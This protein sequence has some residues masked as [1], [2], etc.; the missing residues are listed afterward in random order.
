MEFRIEQYDCLP[1]TN[2]LAMRRGAE[3]EAEG[4]VLCADC[5]SGGKARRGR[6]YFCPSGSGL[7]FSVLLR[8]SCAPEETVLLTAA[9]AAAVCEAADALFGC[10]SAIKWVNDV[11][12]G[13][14]K[15]CGI[16]T[17]GALSP[18]CGMEYAVVGIGVNVYTPEGGFPEALRDT[19]GAL[20]GER[21][22]GEDLRPRLM[23][24]ILTRFLPYYERLP[25][26]IFFDAYRSRSFVLERHITVEGRGATALSLEPDCRLRVRYDDGAE[27]L[28]NSEEISIRL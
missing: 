11:W 22:D 14:K 10:R 17:E 15:V 16:L 7:Y 27:S 9:A 28:L 26:R 23:Q 6:A 20:L 3:G 2:T 13:G 1:S 18:E 21:P 8:P 25:D 19:A 12:C 4:L 24:E 5:Q